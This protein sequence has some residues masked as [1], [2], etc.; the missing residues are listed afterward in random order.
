MPRK[1]L[2]VSRIL[3]Y[4]VTARS[5]NREPFHCSLD[6]VWK[7][8]TEECLVAQI[9][10]GIRI[11]AL[12]LMPNHFHLLLSTP[13]ENLGVVMQTFMAAV[14][15]RLNLLSGRSGRVFGDK[16][17][18]TIIGDPLYFSH[19]YRYVY[20]NP[21]RAGIRARVEEYL[22]STLPGLQGESQLPFPLH[23]PYNRPDFLLIPNNPAAHLEW[24]N[25]P[26]TQEAEEAIRKALRKTEF[27]PPK[28]GWKNTLVDLRPEASL[29]HQA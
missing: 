14:T 11:H 4:H 18:R 26:S 22:Y 9:L 20:R 15:K 5:N 27:A 8:L 28:A 1:K 6:R 10:F 25:Q 21:V 29:T 7:I 19:A 16:Y 12:V 23:F 13:N 24:L 3:P 2:I 17:Y